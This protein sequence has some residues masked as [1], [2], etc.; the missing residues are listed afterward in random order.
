MALREALQ[1][2]WW[3]L[4]VGGPALVLWP[5]TLVYRLLRWLHE[6]PWRWSWRTP[7]R[8]HVPVLVVGN[9][10]VGGA[11]KTPTVIALAQ[12]LQRRG[13]KPGIVSRGYGGQRA[14]AEQPAQVH[15]RSAALQTGDEPLL[16]ALRTGLPVWVCRRRVAAAQALCAHHPE[17]DMIISDDGLQHRALHRDAELLVFDDR[18]VGNGLQMPAGPLREPLPS[19]LPPH[20]RVLY[21]AGSPSTPLAGDCA[22]RRLARI[23]PLPDWWSG[24][25]HGPQASGLQAWQGRQV[26]AAAGIGHPERFFA[27]LEQAGLV[28]ERCPLAD[29]ATLT[30]RPWPASASCVVMTEKDAVKLPPEELSAAE[31]S[32]LHVATLDFE[33]PDSTVDALEQL[34]L[35]LRRP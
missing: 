6:A 16:M 26:L 9:L 30:P 11:G 2:A 8:A 31:R 22:Q 19:V 35:P 28:V 24:V 32:T 27:M 14:D 20:A 33:I 15:P 13:W 5:L 10:V 4:P 3:R 18:G 17:V 23:L 21:N 1:R 29:H 25:A 12:A 34:L 7:W